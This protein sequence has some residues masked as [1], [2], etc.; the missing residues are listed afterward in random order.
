MIKNTKLCM[1][2]YAYMSVSSLLG[3]V[4]FW[5]LKILRCISTNLF[6]RPFQRQLDLMWIMEFLK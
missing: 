2:I 5:F 3:T 6:Y 1:G 4:N